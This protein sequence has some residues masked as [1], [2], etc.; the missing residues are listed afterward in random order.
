MPLGSRRNFQTG[1]Y[2]EMLRD[3][4]L[5]ANKR[6][7]TAFFRSWYDKVVDT[8]LKPLISAANA[9]HDRHAHVVSYCTHG[10]TKAR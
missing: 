1:S 3:L 8:G 9:V 10:I 2:K 7:A 5:L 6:T 4:W